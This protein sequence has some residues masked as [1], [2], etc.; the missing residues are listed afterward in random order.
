MKIHSILAAA[1]LLLPACG[2]HAKIRIVTTTEDLASLARF[3][4]G[5]RVS[6]KSIARGYMDPHFVDAKPSHLL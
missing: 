1:C 3:V 2:A 5:E 4:G 6:V